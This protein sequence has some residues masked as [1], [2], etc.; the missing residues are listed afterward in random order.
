M[1]EK[2]FMNEARETL[3]LT[4]QIDDDSLLQLKEKNYR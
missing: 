3:M 2:I 1:C 4:S